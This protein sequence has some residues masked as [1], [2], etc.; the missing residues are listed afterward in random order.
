MS[1]E[2]H[3]DSNELWFTPRVRTQPGE[4]PLPI[5]RL[6]VISGYA[7]ATDSPI[8]MV[9]S[10]DDPRKALMESY[11]AAKKLDPE[12]AEE[13]YG[14]AWADLSQPFRF[15][16]GASQKQ[17]A[18]TWAQFV[19][20]IAGPTYVMRQRSAGDVMDGR[21]IFEALAGRLIIYDERY[22]LRKTAGQIEAM[23]HPEGYCVLGIHNLVVA[24]RD[25]LMGMELKLAQSL[26]VA[27]L[28][29]TGYL[30][31]NTFAPT[32]HTIFLELEP[33][34]SEKT[35]D[36]IHAAFATI[37]EQ[38]TRATGAPADRAI[39]PRDYGV[40]PIPNVKPGVGESAI[41]LYQFDEKQFLSALVG[42]GGINI[43][44][45]AYAG[46][47]AKSDLG[48][49]IGA[50]GDTKQNAEDVV[51]VIREALAYS[52]VTLLPTIS[53]RPLS[54]YLAVIGEI[55]AYIREAEIQAD[56]ASGEETF[57]REA[58]A[59]AAKLR[60]VSDLFLDWGFKPEAIR[61][62][63]FR[64]A[65]RIGMIEEAPLDVTIEEKAKIIFDK[66]VKAS[67][68]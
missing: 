34:D 32:A 48:R 30:K 44:G 41:V 49:I 16:Y 17:Q 39:N 12:K 65:K 47:E 29:R 59:L 2:Y 45:S 62:G 24:M 1:I 25:A 51:A 53:E 9:T 31:F 52:D 64:A 40:R 42:R 36:A 60:A 11:E 18:H 63:V 61:K 3:P 8:A 35:F 27:Q 23:A 28:E 33:L 19:K 68:A 57:A 43:A 4:I 14:E 20:L 21:P 46:G 13:A 67:V 37:I 26:S 66:D 56:V 50:F 15:R 58:D 7:S 10:I 54:D 5:V 22:F 55:P 38:A 6:P